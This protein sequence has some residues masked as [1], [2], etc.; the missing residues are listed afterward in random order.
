[1][2]PTVFVATKAT[3]SEIWGEVVHIGI[4]SGGADF[5]STITY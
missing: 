4:I 2:L 3:A 5:V 1:M